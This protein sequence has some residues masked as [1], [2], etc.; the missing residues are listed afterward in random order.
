MENYLRITENINGK[1]GENLFCRNM[2]VFVV[3]FISKPFDDL[4]FWFVNRELSITNTNG[5][6]FGCRFAMRD[7]A[8]SGSECSFVKIVFGE[9]LRIRL[10]LAW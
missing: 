6:L 1:F 5:A 9:F 10:H 8:F 3:F 7:E 4:I 2:N